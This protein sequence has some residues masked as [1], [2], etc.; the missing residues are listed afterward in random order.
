MFIIRVLLILLL[1]KTETSLTVVCVQEK[2]DRKTRFSY[3]TGR[4]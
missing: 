1:F 2:W 3:Y 4:F